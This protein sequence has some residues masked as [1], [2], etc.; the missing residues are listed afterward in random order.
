MTPFRER[1][2]VT[3]GAASLAVIAMIVL[4]AFKAEDLP[5]IGGGDTYYA[6]FSEAG[7]L[8]A[9]DEVRVAG[10]R[11]GK[12][13]EISLRGD[14]VIVEFVV[15]RG[16]ALGSETGADI[17]VKTLLGA[18]YLALDPG[19]GGELEP[20]SEIPEART[21]APYDVVEA[22]S[23]LASTTNRIDIDQLST[24]LDTL[25]SLMKGTPE[26]LQGT[27]NGLSRLSRNVAARDQQINTL[28]QN[29]EKVSGVLA[30]RDEELTKLFR[31]GDRLIRA[32]YTRREAVSRLLDSTRQLS[33]ELTT[34]IQ[35]SR[36]DLKPALQQ[37]DQVLDVLVKN[38]ENLDESLRRMGPFY[39]VFANVLG[40][41]PWFDTY[42][43]NLVVPAP[44]LGG[45]Q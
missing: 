35:Q 1:N 19:G 8:E 30:D 26:E 37:L 16:T 24:S 2:P 18:M 12:V 27:L 38:Q 28:L 39:R 15:D 31:D 44:Q 5:L 22:F 41:G 34:L 43:Q 40:N 6:A 10:V 13:R 45:G 14:E 36:A 23:G 42:V 11:V 29:A 3:I 21:T 17:K 33:Q 4:A 9:N 25:T 20:D 32:I 7:G